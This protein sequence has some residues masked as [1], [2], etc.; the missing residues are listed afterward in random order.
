MLV[1]SVGLAFILWHATPGELLRHTLIPKLMTRLA[2]FVIILALEINSI[3]GQLGPMASVKGVIHCGL[4]LT[5][6]LYGLMVLL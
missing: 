1:G 3:R 6:V 2:V 5:A 4:L